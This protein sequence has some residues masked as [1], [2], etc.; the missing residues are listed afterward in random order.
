MKILGLFTTTKEEKDAKVA[1]RT[2][3]ALKR[4]QEALI[5]S[6]EARK[7]EAQETL[8]RLVEGKIKDIDTKTFNKK[9]HDAKVEI[10]LVDKELEIANAVMSDLYSSTDA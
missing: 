9:Y 8:D 5:D 6:L 4:G 3:K 10:T 2:A 1:A 7:D